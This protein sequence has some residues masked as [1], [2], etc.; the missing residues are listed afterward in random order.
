MYDSNVEMDSAKKALDIKSAKLSSTVLDYYFK[1]GRNR[2]LEKYLRLRKYSTSRSSSDSSLQILDA[3]NQQQSQH[4]RVVK[5]MESLHIDGK[6]VEIC[7]I[8][9]SSVSEPE[10]ETDRETENAHKK[11]I[12][13]DA[14]RNAQK[15]TTSRHER[16]Q[17]KHKSYNLNLESNIEINLPALPTTMPSIPSIP[18]V[19][20]PPVVH[21]NTTKKSLESAETQTVQTPIKQVHSKATETDDHDLSHGKLATALTVPVGAESPRHTGNMSALNAETSPASS[22]ASAK[23]RL[24]W[25]SMADIGYNRI[26]DFKSQSNQ[27]LTTFERSALTKFFA[28]H[29]VRF[30]DSLVLMA[31]SD[32]KESPLQKRSFTQSAI[33]MHEAKKLLGNAKNKTPGSSKHSWQQA[34]EKYRDKYGKRKSND[35]DVTSSGIDSTQ[36]MSLSM[37]PHHSTPVAQHPMSKVECG[38]KQEPSEHTEKMTKI[39]RSCQTVASS[40]ETVGVQVEK[41]TDVA[42]TA[43][44]TEY[45]KCL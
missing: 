37:P 27:N 38:V 26:I 8:I 18:I 43:I 13:T 44:Q 9:D 33:E 16:K 23:Y 15:K 3:S 7:D 34:I 28:D 4:E 41:S 22:V 40:T 25:D 17:T 11:S 24:E 5:S 35:L 19:I 42:S 20:Q 31:A 1:Y 12:V 10:K 30:D 32:R 21:E 14:P 45:C 36:F 6:Q 29:G 39:E 2:D